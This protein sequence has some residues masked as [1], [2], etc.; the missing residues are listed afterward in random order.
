M[1]IPSWAITATLFVVNCLAIYEGGNGGW[2]NILTALVLLMWVVYMVALC[3]HL[4]VDV[5]K[6]V[7]E[8]VNKPNIL[9]KG[10]TWLTHT[11]T[12]F[13]FAYYG[14]WVIAGIQTFNLLSMIY[15]VSI[16]DAA[17]KKTL[18]K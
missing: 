17:R 12:M 1:K 18:E 3:C 7:S 10:I 8:R 13:I 15:L 4:T 16:V 9:Q 14:H 5:T 6:E 11:M 2:T